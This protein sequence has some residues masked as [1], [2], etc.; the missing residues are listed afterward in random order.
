MSWQWI[1]SFSDGQRVNSKD[2]IA[3]DEKRNPWSAV[4]DYLRKN[5]KLINGKKREITHL[6][7]LVNN[8]RYNSPTTS[9]NASFHS[10][11]CFSKF[12]IFYRSLGYFGKRVD[13]EDFVG[14]SFK[15]NDYRIINWVSEKTDTCVTQILNVVNPNNKIEEK[16]KII[17]EDI[18][19]QYENIYVS[20][21]RT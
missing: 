10:S 4:L 2:L 16:F 13:S 15:I 19:K 8:K 11:D 21:T 20:D 3:E 7:L 18:E 1:V 6:E 12:W 14:L 9:L 5:P 17:E